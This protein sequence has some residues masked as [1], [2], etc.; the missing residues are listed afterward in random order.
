MREPRAPATNGFDYI[1]V[2]AGTAGCV[3]AARLSEDPAVRVLLVEAG[4]S[5]RGMLTGIPFLTFIAGAGATR[6]WQ[7]TTERIEALNDRQQE[8]S[9]GRI[10]GG[11][12]SVNGMIYLRGSPAEYDAWQRA[13]CRG[14]SY[15]DVLPYFKKLESDSRGIS[16]WH[17]DSGPIKVRPG[18]LNLPICETFLTAAVGSGYPLRSD[19]NA[20]V[21]EGFGRLDCNIDR[22]IRVSSA[23]AYLRPAER[24][25]NLELMTQ[26]TVLRVL[27]ETG[28]ARGIEVLRRGRRESFIAHREVILCAGALNTPALLMRSGVGPA[29]HLAEVGVTTLFDSPA[30]GKNLHNHPVYMQQVRCTEAVTGY[31]YLSPGG[32]ARALYQYVARRSGPIAESV[33][34]VGGF[35][36]TDPSLEL[37]DAFVVMIPFLMRGAK[38]RKPRWSD[39]IPT[40]EGFVL[41][42]SLG[43]PFSTGRIELRSAL[44]ED[45]PRIYPEYFT[46]RRD[47]PALIEAVRAMRHLLNEPSMATLIDR[48]NDAGAFSDDPVAIEHSIRASAGSLSHPSGTCRMGSDSTAVVDPEL[49]VKGIEGL[50]VADNSILPQPLNAGTHAVALMI[51]EKASAMIR[52]RS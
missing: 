14:W 25:Q 44:P 35:F 17:G 47:M 21:N 27:I 38:G 51:G 19:L 48:R 10:V 16:T 12:G 6:N 5:D 52:G 4:G 23:R 9:Q 24:R 41:A 40:E 30:V 13:G 46:D 28:R 3:L 26:A 31:S 29:E 18:E 33:S 8:W 49:R 34:A 22:G 15:A 39:V 11:S 50:R 37:A 2:G 45:T 36:R 42:I 43:R 32:F 20:G 7:F 1:V